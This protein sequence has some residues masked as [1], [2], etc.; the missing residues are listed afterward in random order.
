MKFDN[1]I[2]G[3]GLSG[4]VSGIALAKAGRRVAIIAAGQSTL[5]FGSGSFDL[6]GY[7]S[8]GAVVNHPLDAIPSLPE[9]HPYK[10]VGIDRIPA[11]ATEATALLAEC[12]LQTKGCMEQNHY[13]LTPLGT[14]KPAWLTLEDYLTTDRPDALPYRK[15]LLVNIPGF[16]DFPTQFISDGLRRMGTVVEMEYVSIP[17]LKHRRNSPTEMRSANL[18]KILLREKKLQQIAH[19]VNKLENDVEAII[20]PAIVGLQTQ[21]SLDFIRSKV[22]KPLHFIATLPP[23]VPGVRVQTLL[24]KYFSSLGG[25]Y[26]LG[27][28]VKGGTIRDG[29]LVD[30]ETSLLPDERM[31]A[32]E[33]ILASGSFQSDGLK[34]NYERVYEPIFDLDVDADSDRAKW[35]SQSVFDAQPYMEYG[36]RTNAHLQVQKNGQTIENLYAVGSVLSGHNAIKLADGTGVS[37]LTALAAAKDILMK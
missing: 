2:I 11:L 4:L 24:R 5:H 31:E 28:T 20:M 30:I 37:I 23:S 27:N 12:G 33:F 21:E 19:N 22:K 14:L 6:L 10:K 36:V 34:S 3:G 25:I 8:E 1:I 7:D 26:L 16:L 13:R 15:V 35:V 18:A 29:R 17:S 32:K 9:K